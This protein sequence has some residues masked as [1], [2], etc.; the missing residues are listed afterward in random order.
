MRTCS[1]RTVADILGRKCSVRTRRRECRGVF[2][3]NS[4]FPNFDGS[5]F[6]S[7]RHF[8]YYWLQFFILENFA[9]RAGGMTRAGWVA[10]DWRA[11]SRRTLLGAV[12]N[13]ES[14]GWRERREMAVE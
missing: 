10:R 6:A 7:Y 5:N 9:W 4:E 14:E 12:G 2:C 1:I 3:R 8:P 13:F 11:E